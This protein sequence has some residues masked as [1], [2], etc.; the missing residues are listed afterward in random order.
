[1]LGRLSAV[2][3]VNLGLAA[4]Y[5]IGSMFV[6]LAGH[7]QNFFELTGK[8]VPIWPAHV[9]ATSVIVLVI[10]MLMAAV[11]ALGLKGSRRWLWVIPGFI[12]FFAVMETFELFSYVSEIGLDPF[13]L[14][15]AVRCVS[16]LAWFSL[17]V[18]LFWRRR[19]YSS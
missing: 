10:A 17:S 16:L 18:F 12:L 11:S 19:L 5:A 14:S 13:P 2:L 8:V 4:W 15:Y 3:F 6:L 9:R 1:M 7:D